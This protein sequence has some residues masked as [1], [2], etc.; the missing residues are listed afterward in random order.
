VVIK[1][2]GSSGSD[3]VFFCR[4]ENAVVEAHQTIVGQMNP[5]GVVNEEVVMQEFLMG[6][7]Y[8]VDTIS[9][10]GRHIVVA[11]WVYTKRKG[12]PWNP[13]C[14]ISEGNRLLPSEG[15]VQD[16]LVDYVF[17][18]LDAVGLRHGPCHTEIMLTPDGPRLVEVNAR[19]HGL[20][21][22]KLIELATGT[23]KAAYAVDVLA[24]D[25]SLFERH[26]R[27][28][29][30]RWRYPM[31]KA[32]Q[33]VVLISPVEGYLR[34]AIDKTIS[35]FDLPSLVDVLPSV[36]RGQWLSQTSDLNNSAGFVLLIHE[37]REQLEADLQRIREAEESGELYEV[38]AE[39]LPESPLG[40][41]NLS[42]QV[43]MFSVKTSTAFFD[44]TSSA[45]MNLN[46]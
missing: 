35:G 43:A 12:T 24:G 22:P 31:L 41:P 25:R 1:P 34:R 27:S 36:K 46:L 3:G 44:M 20:Q 40:S 33:Q 18:V 23:S 45:P 15:A 32:C 6:D 39:P 19:L 11:V 29:E 9:C 7:E 21:G 2:T 8:I 37:S 17:Q 5:N 38:S 14:V 26:Y 4:D 13:T 30:G 16:I 42:R 28:G 10:D